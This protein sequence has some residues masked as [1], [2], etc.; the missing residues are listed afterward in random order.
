[1]SLT[2]FFVD[3]TVTDRCR[4]NTAGQIEVGGKIKLADS[5]NVHSAFTDAAHR[6]C[7]CVEKSNKRFSLQN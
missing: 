6:L 3:A 2:L 7:N 5:P 1:M 4:S